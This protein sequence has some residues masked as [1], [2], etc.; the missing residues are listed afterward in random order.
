MRKKVDRPIY[1]RVVSRVYLTGSVVVSLQSEQTSGG[2]LSGGKSQEIT[3]L[4]KGDEGA[5]KN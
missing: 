2:E 4:E 3:L 1:V 5:V